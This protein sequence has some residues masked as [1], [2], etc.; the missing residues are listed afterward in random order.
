MEWNFDNAKRRE[1]TEPASPLAAAG[2][3]TDE[4]VGCCWMGQIVLWD[5]QTHVSSAKQGVMLRRKT[6]VVLNCFTHDKISK[7]FFHA[8][9]TQLPTFSLLKALN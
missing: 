2:R 1:N 7:K 8:A 6:R 9:V 3:M 4:R 5:F